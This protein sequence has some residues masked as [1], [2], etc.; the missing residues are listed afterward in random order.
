MIPHKS[1]VKHDP[2]NSH[3][4]CIRACIASLLDCQD[5][6]T[7]PHFCVDGAD[8]E[9]VAE[10]VDLFLRKFRLYE[11]SLPVRAHTVTEALDFCSTYTGHNHYLFSGLSRTG[12]PH[13]VIAKGSEIVHDPTGTGIVADID[14]H[15]WLSVLAKRI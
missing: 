13:V 4:D 6:T 14:G 15:Y 7:V 10:R 1:R 11:L 12:C 9:T 5:A 2:P 3:G 8:N